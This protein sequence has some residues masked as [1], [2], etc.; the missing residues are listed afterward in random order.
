[1]ATATV[2][3]PRSAAIYCRI[4]SDPGESRL[5]VERQEADC[6]ALAE[7][8]GW[9]VAE[10]LVDN[11]LSAAS[12]KPRPQYQRLLDLIESGDIDAVIAWDL[13]RLHRRPIELEQFFAACDKAGVRHL[14]SVGG[15]VDLASG[16]GVMVARIKGAV[17]AEEVRKIQ[18]RTRRKKLEIAESGR[19]SGGGRRPF[20]FEADFVTANEAE[21]AAVRDAARRVIAGEPL[22]AIARE[23][24]ANGPST[25]YGGIWRTNAIH[26]VLCAPRTAG[27]RQHQGEVIGAAA[28]PA[29]L[30]RSTWETVCAVL[31]DPSRRMNG[32]P[33]TYLLSGGLVRCASCGVHMVGKPHEPGKPAYACI[34]AN[35]GCN[36]NSLRAEPLEEMVVSMVL[37]ALDG[38]ALAEARRQA[39]G[40]T[41]ADDPAEAVIGIEA[42]LAELAETWA[43]GEITKA[44][45]MT[46][47][48]PL[49]ARLEAARRAMSRRRGTTALDAF[50]GRPKALREEW[51]ALSMER[52]RA[53]I[54]AVVDRV[55]IAKAKRGRNTFDP[56]RVE[57]IWKA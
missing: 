11:D 31:K 14:A 50:S 5:G 26:K 55:N 51:Q 30:D 43:A 1:M 23:W 35:G 29:I 20:G 44:E 54:E 38:P 8:K 39:A 13:D 32:A 25:V 4:S 15:D 7:R 3:V 42:K 34:G 57:I 21:A 18:H 33:R 6:R 53:I 9:P 48:K 36:G 16:E 47:R 12:G 22:M 49:E 52:Q 45:W 41:T 27:L 37:E 17:A 56:S 2:T 46:A 28:W 24:N 40:E 10:V 19:P